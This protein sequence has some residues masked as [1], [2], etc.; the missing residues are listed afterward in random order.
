MRL[1]GKKGAILIILVSQHLWGV[2]SLDLCKY[3]SLPSCLS[4]TWGNHLP[5]SRFNSNILSSKKLSF[6][7]PRYTLLCM[8]QGSVPILVLIFFIL[9]YNHVPPGS[10]RRWRISWRAELNC[11]FISTS[12]VH[13]TMAGMEKTHNKYFIT[14]QGMTKRRIKRGQPPEET[15]KFPLTLFLCPPVGLGATLGGICAIS[16]PFLKN[17]FIIGWNMQLWKWSFKRMAYN[18]RIRLQICVFG[19]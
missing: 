6:T 5:P 16:S 8:P 9:Y 7:L 4:S 15:L 2:P 14:E 12:Q 11:W 18:P 3:F 10:Q 17:I 19:C 1:V 13:S